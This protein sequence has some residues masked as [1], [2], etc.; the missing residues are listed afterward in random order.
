[1]PLFRE[2]M[3]I[4]VP[5]NHHLAAQKAI[6]VRDLDGMNYINRAN[7]D[8]TTSPASAVVRAPASASEIVVLVVIAVIASAPFVDIDQCGT[9][10]GIEQ[11][12]LERNAAPDGN[13]KNE[14]I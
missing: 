8:G 2:Q 7:C 10:L 14:W 12:E 1:M 4:V 13:R 11:I 3:M 5:P 9:R 6:R